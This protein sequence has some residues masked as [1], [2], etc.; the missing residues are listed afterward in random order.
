MILRIF[1][2]SR[3]IDLTGKRSQTSL[4]SLLIPF[5][6]KNRSYINS[7]RH[8]GTVF[9]RAAINLRERK[10]L[11]VKINFITRETAALSRQSSQPFY[12]RARFCEIARL[13]LRKARVASLPTI[14][15]SFAIRYLAAVRKI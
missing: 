14:Y 4:S 5:T 15:N 7:D 1:P 12:E 2:Y 3:I 13:H 8:T 9:S 11:S 10:F 6:T